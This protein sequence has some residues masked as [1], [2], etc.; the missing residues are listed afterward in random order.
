M[1]K[2]LSL[3]VSI[4]VLCNLFVFTSYAQEDECISWS[5]AEASWRIDEPERTAAVNLR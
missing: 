5:E 4:T 2:A 1:K 3:I